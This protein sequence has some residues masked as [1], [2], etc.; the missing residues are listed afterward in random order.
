MQSYQP[1]YHGNIIR[2]KAEYLLS[3]AARDGSFLIRDSESIQGAYALCVL[4]QNCVY[5][6]RILPNEDRKLSVQASEGVPIRFFTMLTELV[7]AYYSPNMGLVTHLQFSVQREEEVDEEQESNSLPP[8]LPPRNF[9]PTDSKDADYKSPEQFCKSLSDTYLMRLQHMDLS[10]ISEEHQMAIQEYFMNSICLDV[11]QLQNGNPNLPGLKK[12]I[13]SICK[14]LNSEISNVLPTL[15]VVHKALD[16]QLSPGFGQYP[17]IS[18]DSGQSVSFRL[19]RLTKLLYSIE[20]KTKGSVFEMVG[21]EG[22]H[23]KSL[24][25]AV[26]FEVKQESL[27]ISTKMF[28]KVDVES[29]KLYFKKSKDGPEDKYFVHNKILQLVKS[30]T[31]HAKLVIMLET[32]KEKVLKKDFVFDDT[33]KR[34]GFCQLLQQ[35][36]NKYSEKPEPDM[37]SVF[38]GTWNMGNASPPHKMNTW[39]QCKGQGKTRD[40]TAD[41]IPHDIY[42]IGTQEDPLGEREWADTVKGAL[43]NITNISFKQ[44]ATHT[45]WNIRIVVLAKPEHENRIS[46]IFSDSVKT[47][48]A[49][50]LGNKGAVGVSF[51]FNRTSFGFVNS[52]LTSGTEKKLRRNQNYTNILRFLNLGDKKLNPFDINHRF[53]HLFWLGDLNYRVEFP[54]KEAEY[55]VTKIKQQQYQEL[56]CKDQLSTERNDGKVFLHFD[57]EEITFA[58]TYRFERDTRERYAYTK[59]KA[60]GTKYNLPSWCDRVLRK[61]Y[62]LVHVVCQAYGCTNDIMTSDHSPVFASFEVGVTSQFV[63]KQDPDSAPEGGIQIMNCVA[64]LLT[65]SKTKFFIEYHSS[66]LEKSAKTSEGENTEHAN[67]SIKVRFGNQVVL[68]P[69]ISDP[70]Y[71]LDQHILICVKSTDSD[72]SYGEGCVALRAAQF[73]YTEFQVTL[74][75]HG[76]KTGVLTGGIQLKTSEGKCTEKLYDFIQIERDDPATSKCKGGD[77]NRSSSAQAQDFSNPNYMGVSY[78]SGNVVDRGWSYSMPPKTLAVTGQCGKD[79]KKGGFDASI[80]SPTGKPSPTNEDEKAS[81]MF[82]NPLYGAMGKSHGRG[83]EQ[84]FQQKDHL[85]PPDP[86]FTSTRPA[87][88]GDA[89]R[90]PVPTPRNRS[91]TCSEN[92][93]QLPIPG[94][95]HPSAHK[96][97]VVPS[98]SE[99]GIGV[100]RPPLPAKFRPGMPD[101][102][103]SK[104]RDYRENSELPNKLRPPT[105]PGQSQ[106][107]KD[108]HPDVSKTGRSVK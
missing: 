8:Q 25:P 86:Q 80:R 2:S 107:H 88:D 6:Y 48:I 44:V 51:M 56:L 14:T 52:H 53:T 76:E 12:L 66:C 71:L 91:F 77:Y 100:S 9:P 99:S 57:E 101:P 94:T 3:K 50:T 104:P 63:S 70:E 64:T 4:Y 13:M 54:S 16:Q 74:T 1:W 22:G 87:T 90:P 49:N 39:F 67:G 72:E 81:G 45:L 24:I 85:T 10:T 36:K 46:H 41:H 43:R 40:D 7:E 38:V 18:A 11:E 5:T 95:S 20:D 33:K 83:K 82:D 98:R 79:S 59:A 92:K 26:T 60:T 32:E 65:K 55:I 37:I 19:E 78:K 27:G 21:F 42:V 68:T 96:K 62:P 93:P 84:D 17:K 103:P 108:V 105:R 30:Q 15:E 29:G 31:M 35:M 97:P 23:R 89:E 47:G 69:I 28:L 102:Q 106:P 34:E 75:H 61:S 73:C 58:P